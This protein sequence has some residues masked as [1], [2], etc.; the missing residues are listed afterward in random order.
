MIM[1][2]QYSSIWCWYDGEWPSSFAYGLLV[3]GSDGSDEEVEHT[4]TVLWG[5]F[6]FNLW[7]INKLKIDKQL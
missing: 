1:Y 6:N 4:Y 2:L 7:V 3:E 5:I